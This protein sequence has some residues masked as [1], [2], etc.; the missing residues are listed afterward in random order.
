MKIDTKLVPADLLPAIRTMW[1]VSA[2]KINSIDCTMDRAKGAPVHTVAGKY[3]PRGWTDWTQGFEFGSAILQFDATGDE[4]FLE[5]GLDRIRAEMPAHVTHF[6]VHD[7]G[8]NKVS[9]YGNLRRLILEG[10]IARSVADSNIS[11]SPSNARALSRRPVDRARRGLRLYP[12]LQRPAFAVHRHHAH[13][14]R[15]GARVEARPRS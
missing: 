13:V 15:V 14:P 9:T 5:L 8:F 10:R 11:N 3:Q 12:F 7:H 1:D 4:R 2:V 6:G